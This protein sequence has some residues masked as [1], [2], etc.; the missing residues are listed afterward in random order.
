MT[1][2]A[3]DVSI[4]GRYKT[5]VVD[6]EALELDGVCTNGV[7]IAVTVSQHFSGARREWQGMVLQQCAALKATVTFEQSA[8]YITSAIISAN[9]RIDLPVAILVRVGLNRL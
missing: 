1:A 6:R 4:T 3:M 5:V 7:W 9:C 8:T 2:K